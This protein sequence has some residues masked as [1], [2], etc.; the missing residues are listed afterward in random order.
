MLFARKLLSILG[1]GDWRLLSVGLTLVGGVCL[2][3]YRGSWR[4]ELRVRRVG[5]EEMKYLK[6]PQSTQKYL[7][8][9]QS[10]QM[11]LEITQKYLEVNLLSY[12]LIYIY[13]TRIDYYLT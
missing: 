10:T 12:R 5:F 2:T 13:D 7:K 6:I 4:I 9:P 8:I 11:Y 1:K 3:M